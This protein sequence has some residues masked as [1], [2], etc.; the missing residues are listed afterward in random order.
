MQAIKT[1]RE[2]VWEDLLPDGWE[3]VRSFPDNVDSE[4]NE[5]LTLTG[6]K[7]LSVALHTEPP[8]AAPNDPGMPER[9]TITTRYVVSYNNDGQLVEGNPVPV[10]KDAVAPTVEVALIENNVSKPAQAMAGIFGV[11]E[12][13][14]LHPE[15]IEPAPVPLFSPDLALSKYGQLFGNV[16]N[17]K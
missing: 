2:I 8:Y 13:Y 10:I 15:D 14:R 12:G 5:W 3:K 11:I 9:R 17:G 7:L 4:I 6:S 1:F 16:N